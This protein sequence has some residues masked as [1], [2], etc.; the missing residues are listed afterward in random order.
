MPYSHLYAQLA[1]FF[2]LMSAVFTDLLLLRVCLVMA[3]ALL[4]VAAAVGFPLRQPS[5]AARA[6]NRTQLRSRKTIM[7]AGPPGRRRMAARWPYP[8]ADRC[9]SKSATRRARPATGEGARSSKPRPRRAVNLSLRT[10]WSANRCHPR[11]DFAN[12]GKGGA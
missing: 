2:F 7:A 8:A 5:P 9:R 1:S 4:V 6:P 12:G 3:N 11:G 10:H